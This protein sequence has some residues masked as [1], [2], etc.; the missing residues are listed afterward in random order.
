MRSGGGVFVQPDTTGCGGANSSGDLREI[1]AGTPT[2]QWNVT[3]VHI[4]RR[5]RLPRVCVTVG[6]TARCPVCVSHCMM[7]R[8]LQGVC[9]HCLRT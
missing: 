9:P 3:T 5:H 1:L 7:H 2:P 8:P 4:C 6:G